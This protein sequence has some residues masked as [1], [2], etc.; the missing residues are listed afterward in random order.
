MENYK[1]FW[2]HFGKEVCL[3]KE[4]KRAILIDMNLDGLI[5]ARDTDGQTHLVLDRN[6]I[7]FLTDK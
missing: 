4:Q 3:V 5:V 7:E 2:Y 1:S 6:Q